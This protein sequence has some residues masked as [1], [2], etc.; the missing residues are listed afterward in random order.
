MSALKLSSLLMLGLLWATPSFAAEFTN[1]G[2]AALK[3]DFTKQIQSRKDIKFAGSKANFTGDVDVTPQGGFYKVT[4]PDLK[5]TDAKGKTLNVGKIVMN[6]IP[7]ET[8]SE[9]KSSFSLPS[10]ISY[11]DANGKNPGKLKFGSQKASGI[12]SMQEFGFKTMDATYSDI[13][14]RDDA[15]KQGTAISDLHLTYNFTKSA[16]GFSGPVTADAKDISLIDANDTKAPLAGAIKVD[17]QVASDK[18][19]KNGYTQTSDVQ[20]TGIATAIQ[21]LS[22]KLKDPAQPNKG[23]LQKMLGILSVLQMSGKPAGASGVTSYNLVTDAQG[24][25]TLNGVDI[26]ILMTAAGS[27]K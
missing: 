16:N 19:A 21:S 24:R 26:S 17:S 22:Q 23:Q 7:T 5:L 10:V 27:G 18:S 13:T 6:V 12:W 8:P 3:A 11:A 1:E 4:L 15:T 14:Y 9:L 2:A 25:T 20:I